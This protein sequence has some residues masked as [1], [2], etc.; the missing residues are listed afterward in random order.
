MTGTAVKYFPAE[1]QRQGRNIR[2]L[3]ESQT[4]MNVFGFGINTIVDVCN[5][6]A[7]FVLTNALE[8]PEKIR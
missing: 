3:A 6:L 2:N 5:V 1:K 8:Q 7:I 4:Q